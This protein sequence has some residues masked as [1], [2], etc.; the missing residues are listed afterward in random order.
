MNVECIVTSG[1]RLKLC[2]CHPRCMLSSCRNFLFHPIDFVFDAF[3]HPCISKASLILM[4]SAI[5][6][7]V[8]EVPAAWWGL[9]RLRGQTQ[10]RSDSS[11]VFSMSALLAYSSSLSANLPC[12]THVTSGLYATRSYGLHELKGIL[13]GSAFWLGGV[14]RSN[15]RPLQGAAVCFRLSNQHLHVC[16]PDTE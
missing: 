5:E 14:V 13:V 11:L 3:G 16:M 10:P 1:V 4:T 12:N 8:V 7:Q 9:T 6:Q 2:C 15:V